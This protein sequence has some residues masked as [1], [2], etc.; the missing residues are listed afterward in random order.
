MAELF[1]AERNKSDL[2]SIFGKNDRIRH[3]D[4]FGDNPCDGEVWWLSSRKGVK[5]YKTAANLQYRYFRALQ[6]RRIWRDAKTTWAQQ[7]RRSGLRLM[8]KERGYHHTKP[9]YI[10]AHCIMELLSLRLWLY[11][12]SSIS[13]SLSSTMAFSLLF[14]NLIKGQLWQQRTLSLKIRTM[15]FPL[16]QSLKYIT[17]ALCRLLLPFSKNN[18]ISIITSQQSPLSSLQSQLSHIKTTSTF[19]QKFP[20]FNPKL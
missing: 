17:T 8:M 4:D 19:Y 15:F 3:Q 1:K 5:R 7:I 11:L 12:L 16:S 14:H 9:N 13:I 6:R 2:M 10:W 18:S 20:T